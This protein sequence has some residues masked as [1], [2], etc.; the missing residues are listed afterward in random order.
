M[1]IALFCGLV[2]A[3]LTF[4]FGRFRMISHTNQA[5]KPF[6][7][8]LHGFAR[9]ARD[10]HHCFAPEHACPNTLS[11]ALLSILNAS[12]LSHQD[13]GELQGPVVWQ[14]LQLVTYV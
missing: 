7:I 10:R 4:L 11:L 9:E 2:V 1:H 14:L 3:S 13:F 5:R 12:L 6:T 8:H